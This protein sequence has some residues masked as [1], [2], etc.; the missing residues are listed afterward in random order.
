MENKVLFH[1]IGIFKISP[2]KCKSMILPLLAL[3]YSCS[4]ELVT[5]EGTGTKNEIVIH[6]ILE[7]DT[8]TITDPI[9]QIKELVPPPTIEMDEIPPP[10]PVEEEVEIEEIFEWPPPQDAQFPGGEAMLGEYITQNLRYPEIALE[11][12]IEGVVYVGFIVEIDGSISNIKIIHG[13]HAI[14]D[15]E[16]IRVI[17]KMPKWEPA[18]ERM[19]NVRSQQS[20]PFKFNLKY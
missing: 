5:H 18:T 2:M 12:E 6:D 19:R 20:I 14:L 8:S 11:M 4:D 9:P 16:A 7:M 17:K 1:R 10:P 15:K 3:L 13:V